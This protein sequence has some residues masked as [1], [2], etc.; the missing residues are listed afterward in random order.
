[1][2]AAIG[3]VTLLALGLVG[4]SVIESCQR[5]RALPPA[6]RSVASNLTHGAAW[7]VLF[8]LLVLLLGRPVFALAIGWAL[9]FTLVMVN[10]AKAQ[11]LKEPFVFDDYDYFVDAIRHPRLFLPFLG[12]VKGLAIAVVATAVL[13]GGWVIEPA[14][15]RGAGGVIVACGFL[16]SGLVALGVF[17]RRGAPLLTFRPA[18]DHRRHGMIA[19]LAFQAAARRPDPEPA[20]P[21]REARL[22]IPA[23]RDLPHV[24]AV[25]SE[26][27]FDPRTRLPG[28]RPAVLSN[29]DRLARDGVAGRLFVPAFGANTVRSEFAFL[30]GVPNERLGYRRFSPYRFVRPGHLDATFVKFL[31]E[32]G[33]RTVC[34]HPY[35]GGFYRRDRVMSWLGFDEFVDIS[36]FRDAQGDGP[37]VSDEALA[38]KVIERLQAADRPLFVFVITMENHGPLHPESPFPDEASDYFMSG[39]GQDPDAIIYLRHLSNA[40][41]MMGRL[42]AAL[43]KEERPGALCWFGDHPPILP[44][45]YRTHGHPGRSTDYLLWRTEP[46]E[47]HRPPG[48]PLAL[49]GLGESLI[50]LLGWSVS[51]DVARESG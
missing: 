28:V 15:A 32:A 23:G 36:A 42:T 38:D 6:R 20:M 12:A 27:F 22:S 29:F 25:Q 45:A 14:W 44:S 9:W 40:D 10:N 37:Y 49:H 13:V 33:Y 2:L 50:T 7:T 8:S 1:M 48:G 47:G 5:P 24:V 41:R 46:M 3:V 16:V 31:R 26:S 51:K 39:K 21:W 19:H 11:A 43:E 35:H 17:A 4:A 30:S 18:I 34:V